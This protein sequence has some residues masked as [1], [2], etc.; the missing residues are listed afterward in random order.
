MVAV[1]NGLVEAAR[2]PASRLENV[3][4]IVGR[5]PLPHAAGDRARPA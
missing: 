1:A 3:A 2:T 5:T 4:G